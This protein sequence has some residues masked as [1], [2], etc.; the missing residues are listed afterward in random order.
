[1]INS[2]TGY[3]TAEVLVD[4]VKH[5]VEIKT[6]NSKYCEVK[7]R[8]PLELIGLD[9]KIQGHLKA[10]FHR[11]RIELFLSR[12]TDAFPGQKVVVNYDLADQYMKAFKELRKLYQFQHDVGLNNIIMAKEVISLGHDALDMDALWDSLS[13]GIDNAMAAVDAMR[14]EEGRTL[15]IDLAARVGRIREWTTE[16]EKEA[17]KVLERYRKRLKTRVEAFTKQEIDEQRLAQETVLFADRS[18]IT[19]EIVRI[20]SHLQQFLAKLE[21]DGPIG[22]TLD[23]LSQELNREI[24]T[25]A[26]KCNSADIAQVVVN[27]KTELEK[28]REQ[29]QNVE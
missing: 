11:G 19:E 16:V 25:V 18:D 8:L 14:A 1:M 27:I 10:H 29:S 5:F 3:G 23:F 12:E 6:L 9:I 4:G 24:N 20:K 22:R 13:P 7:N 26:S 28:I 17:P 21:E 15:A 2:M